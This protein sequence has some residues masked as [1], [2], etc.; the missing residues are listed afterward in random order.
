MTVFL[1]LITSVYGVY[2]MIFGYPYFEQYWI[3]NTDLYGSMT[4]YNAQRALATYSNAEEWGR[5]LLLGIIVAAG[6][7]M[8][9]SEGKKRILWFAAAAVLCGMLAL[10]GQRSSI[11]GVI[12]GVAIL[13]FTSAKTLGG[14]ALRVVLISV[15]LIL[16]LFIAKP[17]DEDSVYE[18][19]ESD[20]V[21]AM[22]S[23]TAKGTVNPTGEGSLYVRFETWGRLAGVIASKP[24]GLGLGAETLAAHREQKDKDLA[25]DNYFFS[26]ALSTGIPGLLLVLWVLFRAFYFCW[27]GWRES[28][29]HSAQSDMWRIALALMSSFILNNFFG[30]SFLIYSVAPIGWLLVG[31]ISAS[32]AKMQDDSEAEESEDEADYDF[33][34][35]KNLKRI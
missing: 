25:T 22:L 15:P 33:L 4:V 3:D 8:S 7:G 31:W 24:F 26:L 35:E 29:P 2:Q 20:R 19:D 30:T 27:R 9:R 13:I 28:E 17:P 21:T 14:G 5:Y 6:F 32:Y 18:L 10:T 23:H 1:G 34:D 16:I 11:F 12:V